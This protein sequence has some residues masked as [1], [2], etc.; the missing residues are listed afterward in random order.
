MNSNSIISSFDSNWYM[1]RGHNLT[2]SHFLS[3]FK[4]LPHGGMAERNLETSP[5][6]K[7]TITGRQA[8]RQADRQTEK[9]TYRGISFR[10]AQK[11]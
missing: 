2:L 10:S 11:K 3:S 9:A 5:L 1:R 8:G 7:L 4:K 6:Y